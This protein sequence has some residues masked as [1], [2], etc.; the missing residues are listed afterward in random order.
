MLYLFQL[1][2]KRDPSMTKYSGAGYQPAAAYQAAFS[3]AAQ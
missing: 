2:A 3:R 1:P